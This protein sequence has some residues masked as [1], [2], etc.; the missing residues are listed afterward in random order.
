MLKANKEAITRM[1][2]ADP[3]LVNIKQAK[4]VLKGFSKNIFLHAGPPIEFE[5]MCPPMKGAVYCALIN[6]GFAKDIEEAKEIAVSGQIIYKPCHEFGV[7]GPMTGLTTWSMPLWVIEDKNTQ[8]QAY[9]NVSEGQGVGLR[10][11][12]YS[13]KTLQRLN[14]IKDVFM[15][16]FQKIL[17]QDGP[18]DLA[19]IMAQGLAM[20]DELHMRNI[21]TTSL[22]LK[23]F[24][25]AIGKY[26]GEHTA[27]ILRFI[28]IGNDQFFLNLAMGANKLI[29]D[30]ADGIRGSTIVTA[31]ARNGV[32][33]GIRISGLKGRWFTAPAPMIE[34]LYFPGYTEK[35]ANPDLGDSAIMEVGG[36]GGCAMIASPAIIKFLGHDT[37]DIAHTTTNNMYKIAASTNPKY[38]IPIYDFKGIPLGLDAIK[39]VETGITPVLNT[40]I[41][42]NKAGAGMVGA[43]MSTVPLKP[44]EDAL[45]ALADELGI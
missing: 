39:I 35:D 38:Q 37:V 3:I 44:F 21:A 1:A 26:A 7:V 18:V 29:A 15:P 41:A 19:P 8:Q 36:F 30:M 31:I 23:H 11:G 34:G 45:Y 43:G 28:S 27:D 16:I 40:A 32:E 42:S 12:E 4:D 10:F 9:V 2:Q 17:Q 33:V 24:S 20:G 14:W 5:K 6:E 22:I 13:Q 25:H